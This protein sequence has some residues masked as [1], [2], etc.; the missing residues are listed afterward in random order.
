MLTPCTVEGIAI[1]EGACKLMDRHIVIAHRSGIRDHDCSYRS[2]RNALVSG[3]GLPS[4][5]I[6]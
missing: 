2:E 3:S 4:S 6:S 5:F 1:F